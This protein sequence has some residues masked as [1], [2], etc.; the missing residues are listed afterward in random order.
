MTKNIK[1]AVT[2]HTGFLGSNV[3]SKLTDYDV[4]L[5]GRRNSTEYSLPFFKVDFAVISQLDNALQNVNVVIHCAAR[6]H[7][8][9]EWLA[10]P[11]TAFLK[12]NTSATLNLA[13]SAAKQGVKRFIY[14]SSIKVLGE[15]TEAEKPFT[16]LNKPNPA[17]SYAISKLRAEHGLKQI[18]KD[19]GMEIVIIRPPL[20]YGNGVKANFLTLLGLIDKRIP[21]PFR[22]VT[23]NRRSMIFVFNLVDLIT[24]CMEHP[25]AANQTLLVSDD[26]DLSTS[27]LIAH[28]SKAM[29]VCNFSLPVPSGLLKLAFLLIRKKELGIRLLSSLEVDIS[30]TKELLSWIPPYSVD[31]GFQESVITYRQNKQKQEVSND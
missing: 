4:V 30:K 28:M 24:K 7:V 6:A 2:G 11:L 9:K 20:I 25:N 22:A 13:L 29:K 14:I 1:V 19:T 15:Y 8:M 18:G 26:N 23:D 3:V 27:Q 10:E 21:L 16:S 12:D 17:D 5:L 31:Y